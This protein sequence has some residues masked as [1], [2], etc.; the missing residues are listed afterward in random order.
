MFIRFF[1]QQ[2]ADVVAADKAGLVGK[3]KD[4]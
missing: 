1:G 3:Y 4:I 2:H